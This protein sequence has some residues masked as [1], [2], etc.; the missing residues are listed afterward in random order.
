M[1]KGLIGALRVDLGMNSASFQKG[2]DKALSTT[3]KM[4]A[5]MIA[6]GT[7]LQGVGARMSLGV[8]L[9]LVAFGKA[10]IGAAEVQQKAVAQMEAALGSMGDAA[11]FTSKELQEVASQ[12]QNK[13]LFGDEEILERV[14]SNLL[15]FGNVS[16]EV[17]LRAQQSALDMSAAIGQD[18]QSSTIMLGKA[19]N[20]PIKGVSALTR[21]GVSLTEQ[22]KEQIRTMSELGDVAG[23]QSLILNELEKQYGGQ[24][25]ALR[26]LDAGRITAASMAIGDAMEAVGAIVLPVVADMAAYVEK[27]AIG[28]QE[29]S[30]ETQKMIVAAGGLA[31][32][33]GPVAAVTGVAVA[34]LS[35]L[36]SPV[37]A[38]VVGVAALG[39]AA[40]YVALNWDDLSAR[41]PIMVD[42]L[43]GVKAAWEL[44]L[45]VVEFFGAQTLLIIEGVSAAL[46]GDWQGAWGAAKEYVGNIVDAIGAILGKLGG[47]ALDAMRALGQIIRD[48][49]S[50]LVERMK[51]FAGEV[52]AG[53]VEGFNRK[54]DEA[55]AAVAG[56]GDD[57]G[58]WFKERLGIKSPSRVFKGYGVNV[59]EGLAIG[60]DGAAPLAERSIK[61]LGE[62]LELVAH[63]AMGGVG[64]ALAKGFAAGD[65]G[66]GLRGAASE[67]LRGAVDSFAE[68]LGDGFKGGG[69][70]AIKDGLSGA[71]AGIKGAFSGGF[72]LSGVGAALSAAMPI[73]GAIS[74]I[75][76]LVKNFSSRVKIDEG[77]HL[78]AG[79][80]GLSGGSFET[81]RR[82]TFW[83][84]FSSTRTN[85][86]EFDA[87]TRAALEGQAGAVRRAVASTYKAAGVAI[88]AGFVEGFAYDFGRI[89]TKG[90]S[91]DD[92]RER[93]GEA[94]AGYGD[95]ISQA[96]GGV[97]LDMA[98]SFAE[99]KAILEPSGQG[100][101]GTF[102]QMA[103]AAGEVADLFGDAAALGGSVSRF[104]DRY[105]SQAE[106]LDMV[107]AQV[108]S[109]FADLG[110]VVPET[111]RAFRELVLSQDL[112]TESG[113]AAYASLMGVS[114]GFAALK[115]GA[116]DLERAFDPSGWYASEFD[117]RLAQAAAARGYGFETLVAQT[118][119]TRQIGS[120]SAIEGGVSE[121]ALVKMALILEQMQSEGIPV[122]EGF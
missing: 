56:F 18:L 111:A 25:K 24:A 86:K 32:A 31:A 37:G 82:K 23:A 112:M 7:R 98:A 47:L 110:L 22:Q 118:A 65:L 116:G 53:F 87:E 103:G 12:L 1:F 60:I 109:V 80:G 105:F 41:F 11:G 21:V 36:V 78:S 95:A 40:A 115:G 42:A 120:S 20:D 74:S 92:I 48:E 71:W 70:G 77:L 79:G 66:A 33:I 49:M 64:D 15:T 51:D 107:A 27:L 69:F 121:R 81:W 59:V 34:G 16:G 8:T 89:S 2:A 58:G 91:E 119:G 94:F 3:A 72:S 5:G 45:P 61:G 4:Q 35:A 73:V 44:L 10:S 83:G 38:V 93:L 57:V 97:A 17:F 54:V 62:R 63:R 99:V 122:N 113:R 85:L 106:R 14:T 67:Y 30:P 88:E 117:A 6:A 75:V 100:F 19:L 76:G 96:L 102:A 108:S 29:L 90:L 114:D 68:V 52:V 104:V 55:K 101:R 13:S 9:P 43:D 28:F 26:N 46:Q 84:L 50:A 39:A